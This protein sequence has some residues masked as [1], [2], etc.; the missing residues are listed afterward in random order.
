MR[1]SHALVQNLAILSMML[2][3]ALALLYGAKQRWKF[4]VDP[5]EWLWLCYSQ[6]FLKKTFGARF[7]VV[8]TYALGALLLVRKKRGRE[9]FLDRHR[10]VS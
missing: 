8:F 3:A 2:V 6:A 9:S 7:V 1:D 4:L 5:P 10:P